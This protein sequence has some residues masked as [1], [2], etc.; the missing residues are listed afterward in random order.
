MK[1]FLVLYYASA[2]AMEKMK[3]S[4]PKDHEDGMKEWKSW[5]DKCANAVVDF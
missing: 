2:E 5:R 1:K 4:T 3:D